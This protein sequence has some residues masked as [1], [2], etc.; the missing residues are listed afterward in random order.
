MEL[1][2]RAR[3]KGF[4]REVREKDCYAPFREELLSLW[5]DLC[6]GKDIPELRFSDFK[7]YWITGSRAEYEAVYFNRRLRLNASVFL[8]MIYPEQEKYF[9]YLEDILFSIC[10][11]FTWCLP[12]HYGKIEQ[13]NCRK[14]DLFAAETGFALAETYSMI[15]DRLDPLVAQ[16][17]KDEIDRRIIEPYATKLHQLWWES[18]EN[19]WAAV[20]AGSVGCTVM[21]M[22]PER[23]PELRE[24][25]EETMECYLSG[26]G[27]DGICVEGC[28][29]WHYGF[30]FFLVYADM[31][32][33]FTDGEIDHFPRP[34]VRAIATYIQKMFLTGR[35][36]VSFADSGHYL[37]YHLGI[38][39]YLKSVYPE[40]VTVFDRSYSYNYDNCARFCLH[41]RAALWY[42]EEY[43]SNDLPAENYDHFAKGAEWFI[44]KTP[45]YGFAAKGGHNNES[46]NHNDV[47]SF[48]FARN[49]RQILTDPG[50][51]KYCK[52]YFGKQRYTFFH[53]VSKGHSLPII[54]G[55]GQKPGR[56]YCAR[57]CRV[58]NGDFVLDIAGAY[59]IPELTALVRRFSFTD[60]GIMVSDR[61]DYCGTA[62]LRERIVTRVLPSAEIAGEIAV[63]GSTLRYDANAVSDVEI[64]KHTFDGSADAYTV[65]LIL[66]EGVREFS[67]TVE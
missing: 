61:F 28:G 59:G 22:R 12:A 44:H 32:K 20:C 30:G 55:E 34:K 65:D 13:N 35:C 8:S 23:F 62:V 33:T 38:L 3:D 29:Y 21:L 51:G 15:G 31:V 56:E 18:C 24:R 6:E 67:Y 58:E 16:R 53:T 1:H 57:D 45:T 41:L 37:R 47:G 10:N 64:Q 36:A 11:E 63:D 40:E 7:L 2:A 27:E 50:T 60:A 54:G 43:E 46:H 66:R 9:R 49:G 4:W 48:I 26:F 5:N 52:E 14:I 39:H 25:I 19:N 42:R 17:I